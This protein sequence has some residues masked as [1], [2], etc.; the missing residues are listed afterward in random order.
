MIIAPRPSSSQ[1]WRRLR[2]L[3]PCT[4]L[5]VIAFDSHRIAGQSDQHRELMGVVIEGLRGGLILAIVLYAQ[6]PQPTFLCDNGIASGRMSY[7]RW[8]YVR[9]AS[10][11]PDR[12]SV[13]KLRRY[14]GDLFLEIPAADRAAIDAFVREKAPFKDAE[15]R[16]AENEPAGTLLAPSQ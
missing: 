13:L 10:W 8:K 15:E 3:A 14:D 11:L 2:W 9:H 1:R 16:R 4:M 5:V 6:L 12:P 7:I